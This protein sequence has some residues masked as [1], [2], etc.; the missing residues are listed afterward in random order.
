MHFCDHQVDWKDFQKLRGEFKKFILLLKDSLFIK[1]DNPTLYRGQFS[2]ELL[3]FCSSI[4]NIFTVNHVCDVYHFV[5]NYM[6]LNK[7]NNN[8]NVQDYHCVNLK[9]EAQISESLFS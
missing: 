7:T 2:E 8:C 4:L 9:L 3:L 5:K 1:N 6:I